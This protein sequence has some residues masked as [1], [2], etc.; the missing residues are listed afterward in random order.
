MFG[1]GPIELIIILIIALVIFGPSKLPEV[2]RTLGRLIGE[3]KKYSEGK[4]LSTLIIL[5][6]AVIL[7]AYLVLKSRQ[8]VVAS[9]EETWKWVDWRGR[10]RA[11]T[12]YRKVQVQ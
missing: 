7:V 3:V 5:F 11:I 8:S 9:N 1:L 6:G 2:G 4:N 10:E 12:A